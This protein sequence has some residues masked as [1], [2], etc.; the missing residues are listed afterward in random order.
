MSDFRA[1]FLQAAKELGWS[2]EKQIELLC[3]NIERHIDD[4]SHSETAR[5]R[6]SLGVG[7]ER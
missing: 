3:S 6:E 1:R 4:A 7:H 5:E 2:Y